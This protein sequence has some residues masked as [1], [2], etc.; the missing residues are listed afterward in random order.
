MFLVIIPSC[1]AF[2]LGGEGGGRGGEKEGDGGDLIN[3]KKTT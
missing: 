3:P 1:A 2:N